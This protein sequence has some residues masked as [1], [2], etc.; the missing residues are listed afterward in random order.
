MK[1]FTKYYRV[2]LI[3]TI[4]VL[5][6]TGII[7]YWAISLILTSQKDK[8]L[9]VEEQEV[10]EYVRTNHHL[11][12]VFE[13]KD[14]Q[15]TFTR[16]TGGIKRE[17]IT[18][19]YYNPKE[20]ENEKGR[21]LVSSVLV[22]GVN[23][24]I[25]VVESS[26]ET[27]DLIQIIFGITIAVILLL[28][29]VLFIANRLI[30]ARI[31]QPFY[32]ILQQVK[33]FNLNGKAEIDP[34][35]TTIEEFKE[36]NIAVSSMSARVKSDYNELKAFTENASHELLTPIAIINSKLDTLIQTENFTERQSNLLNDVYTSVSRLTRLNQSMLLLSRIENQVISGT[37]PVN[38]KWLI[39][40]KVA[41]LQELYADR[42][43]KL[44]IFFEEKEL[45]ASRYLIEILVNNL[46]VNAIRHNVP[47][48]QI[49]IRLIDNQLVIK[50]TGEDR[51]I[52]GDDIFKRFNKSAGS[53]GTG[54]GLTISAQICDNY[55]FKLNYSYK[56]PFHYFTVAF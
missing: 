27:D 35:P 25:L 36:L 43:I 55:G 4:V 30:L 9:V 29:L 51:D 45:Q 17:F 56:S 39:T 19:N 14:Q 6:V 47:Q 11:P 37:E 50:N 31:W 20:K 38:L 52:S 42:N 2:N 48:G 44:S 13:S 8:D 1:L 18:T 23:Y 49:D 12:Q 28:L 3:I 21:G 41:Q 10:F 32:G 7:Y 26:V 40:D 15:I 22:N 34:Q 5:L 54:L 16:V 33:S 24:K 46:L 53:E